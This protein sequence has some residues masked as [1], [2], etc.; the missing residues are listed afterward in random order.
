MNILNR[1]CLKKTSWGYWE[2]PW[3][4]CT[5][6]KKKIIRHF[7]TFPNYQVL[8]L[9]FSGNLAVFFFDSGEFLDVKVDS[10]NWVQRHLSWL[11]D[12][13]FLRMFDYWSKLKRTAWRNIFSIESH[14]QHRFAEVHDS[15]R[16]A[17]LPSQFLKIFSQW[18]GPPRFGRDSLN[19]KYINHMAGKISGFISSSHRFHCYIPNFHC[20]WKPAP[21]SYLKQYSCQFHL[22]NNWA[23][24]QKT[25][26]W[27]GWFR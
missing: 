23:G 24:S 13:H 19:T 10:S 22:V 5:P 4:S 11:V 20:L 2:P 18:R 21:N 9:F 8:L 6:I 15:L 16:I 27:L 17:L 7:V 14:L 3:P 12:Q 1:G 25:F 26:G